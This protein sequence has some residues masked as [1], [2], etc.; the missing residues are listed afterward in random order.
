MECARLCDFSRSNGAQRRGERQNMGNM[1]NNLLVKNCTLTL[2]WRFVEQSAS[3]WRRRCELA[4]GAR[5]AALAVADLRVATRPMD[6]VA[7]DCLARVCSPV[8]KQRVAAL[9]RFVCISV[10]SVLKWN[11][12]YVQTS[13]LSAHKVCGVHAAPLLVC[14][15]A[16]LVCALVC[17]LICALAALFVTYLRFL[18][19][20]GFSSTTTRTIAI[21]QIV[22]KTIE[23]AANRL[24]NICAHTRNCSLPNLI[25]TAR[26][27]H[28]ADADSAAD[29]RSRRRIESRGTEFATS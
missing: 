17:A 8:N 21:E 29:A 3:V 11:S 27:R 5:A 9:S 26:A 13:M 2:E 25:G 1:S 28:H 18:A 7:H 10:V 15:L 24:E 22:Y 23:S 16:V 20:G 4:A 6:F 12:S 19:A 14:A